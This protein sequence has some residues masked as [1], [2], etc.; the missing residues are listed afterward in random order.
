MK[1]QVL[2]KK[3]RMSSVLHHTPP[4]KKES[5]IVVSQKSI[6]AKRVVNVELG[7]WLASLLKWNWLNSLIQVMLC[8]LVIKGCDFVSTDDN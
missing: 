7:K 6:K 3:K 5:K 8:I 2:E 4:S 1:K